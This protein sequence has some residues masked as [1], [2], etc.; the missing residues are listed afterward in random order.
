AARAHR[1]LPDGYLG[2]TFMCSVKQ[3]DGPEGLT[4]YHYGYPA[5]ASVAPGSPAQRAGIVPGDTIVAYD[6]EDV[7]YRKIVLSRLLR[8]GKQVA[9][10]VRRN[11]WIKELSV[12]IAPRPA[13]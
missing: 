10:R 2:I 12:R 4:I 6:S 3:Q 5:V 8:P 9:V 7:L 11:G 13:T 1:G